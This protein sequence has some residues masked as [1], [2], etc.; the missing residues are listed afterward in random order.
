MDYMS[1]PPSQ[2]KKKGCICFQFLLALHLF[3]FI[4]VL[5]FEL[6]QSSPRFCVEFFQ[7]IYLPALASNRDPCDLCFLSSWDYRRE[8]PV[9]GSS[10]F[11]NFGNMCGSGKGWKVR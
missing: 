4:V 9:L 6:S 2:K 10:A 8:P 7:A 3:Y 1:R 5:E 11:Y